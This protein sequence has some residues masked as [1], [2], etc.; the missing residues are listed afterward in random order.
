MWGIRID[1][2][3]SGGVT[4]GTL[5]AHPRSQ[6][7][8]SEVLGCA[9]LCEGVTTSDITYKFYCFL[10]RRKVVAMQIRHLIPS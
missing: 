4:F 5:A 3:E 10:P 9:C 8:D 1:R 7:E 2:G 6:S